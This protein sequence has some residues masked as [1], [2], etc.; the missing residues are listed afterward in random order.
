MVSKYVLASGDITH[1]YVSRSEFLCE[2]QTAFFESTLVFEI[3]SSLPE[4]RLVQVRRDICQNH[5]F[6]VG[7]VQ[8]NSVSTL[9]QA[10][11][12]ESVILLSYIAGLKLEGIRVLNHIELSAN[13]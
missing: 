6:S 7:L 9:A 10:A 5:T 4:T 3:C 1:E 13:A 12:I 11:G 8:L 2:E